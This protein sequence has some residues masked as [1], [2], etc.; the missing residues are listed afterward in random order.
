MPTISPLAATIMLTRMSTTQQ[1]THLHHDLLLLLLLFD[2]FSIAHHP[3]PH[4]CRTLGTLPCV[5]HVTHLRLTSL[6]GLDFGPLPL[7]A[8][9][10]TP[11][12]LPRR[13]PKVT[14]P[15]RNSLDFF[16]LVNTRWLRYV[17]P[18]FTTETSV[19]TRPQANQIIAKRHHNF[20][21]MEVSEKRRI[22]KDVPKPQTQTHHPALS[23]LPHIAFRF[24]I[25]EWLRLHSHSMAA[26]LLP[27]AFV[28]RRQEQRM[29]NASLC[30]T[31]CT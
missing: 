25:P 13:G 21:S 6:Q 4:H 2:L 19:F 1:M 17:R 24:M 3:L 29:I 9:S 16:S 30:H 18:C 11:L 20:D 26:R 7:A 5:F 12:L 8:A 28:A 10:S 31:P 23:P 27:K 15:S 14:R 22:G